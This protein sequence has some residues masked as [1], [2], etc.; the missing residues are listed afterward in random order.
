MS[1]CVIHVYSAQKGQR[2]ALNP[3]ELE[4]QK[5]VRHHVGARNGTQILWKNSQCTLN[6]RDASPGSENEL[7][8][9][10]IF[11]FASWSPEQFPHCA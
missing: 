11:S 3:L 2:R 5:V 8:K 4:P 10:Q 9:I 7:L 6:S 1:I